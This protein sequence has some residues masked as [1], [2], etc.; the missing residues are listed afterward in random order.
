M[1]TIQQWFNKGCD[2]KDGVALYAS[3]PKHKKNLAKLL[4]R[5]ES[6][7]N[8]MKLKR[9]LKLLAPEP[10]II[11]AKPVVLVSDKGLTYKVKPAPKKQKEAVV[12]PFVKPVPKKEKQSLY[13]HELPEELRPVL[14]EA[15]NLFKELCLLK[16][17]LNEQPENAIEACN[18]LQVQMHTKRQRNTLCWQKIDYYLAH[19][20]LPPITVSKFKDLTPA[21]LWKKDQYAHQNISKNKKRL[22]ANKKALELAVSVSESTKIQRKIAKNEANILRYTEQQIEIKALIDGEK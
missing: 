14:L 2:Y 1:N 5:T 16:V 13:F 7:P 6:K 11:P 19:R 8:L 21:Q 18:V 9:E 15:N 3:L 10:I 4:Q 22:E 17:Q 12:I 20:E